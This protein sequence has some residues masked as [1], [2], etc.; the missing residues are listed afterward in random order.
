M[1]D[2]QPAPAIAAPRADRWRP[3][4]ILAGPAALVSI[5][6]VFAAAG[7]GGGDAVAMVS[8][9]LGIASNFTALLALVAMAIGLAGLP[10]QVPGIRQGFGRL[11]WT[12]ATVGTVLT[13]G[14]YWSS[15]FVQPALAHDAPDAVRNGLASVTAGFVV[16][17][18]VMGLGWVLTAIVLLRT[19][20]LR[21]SGWF[22]ILAA[23]IAITPLPFRYLPLA[24]AVSVA[25]GT[26]LGRR[27]T[28]QP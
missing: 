24:V 2:T 1:L 15:V 18:L 9:G 4:F 6:L 3:A 12:V 10:A 17:Y 8:S 25:C 7:A 22:L 16:S 28:Q 5:V 19:R 20:L 27:T 23:L 26:R 14:A 13:A 11:A 21:V